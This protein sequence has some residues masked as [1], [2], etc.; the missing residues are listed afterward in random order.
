MSIR[1]VSPAA[2]QCET[3]DIGSIGPKRHGSASK[4]ISGAAIGSA[5]RLR[6]APSIPRLA[7]CVFGRQRRPK[8]HDQRPDGDA[9]E[10]GP[11]PCLASSPPMR[12]RK[13]KEGTAML[14]DLPRK[15]A[16]LANSSGAV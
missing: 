12:R 5:V 4:S 13:R 6:G 8:L 11:T 7:L 15:E 16:P 3:P 10:V 9:V 2:Q 14:F 1:V